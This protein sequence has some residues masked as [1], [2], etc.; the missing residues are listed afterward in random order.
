MLACPLSRRDQFVCV[1]ERDKKVTVHGL[2]RS[3]AIRGGQVPFSAASWLGKL[4]TIEP[5]KV[6]DPF[7]VNAYDFREANRTL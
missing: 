4:A 6:P 2:L 1:L 5:K 7:A 3:L